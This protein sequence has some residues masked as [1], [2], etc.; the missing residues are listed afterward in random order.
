MAAAAKPVYRVAAGDTTGASARLAGSLPV[1]ARP[2]TNYAAADLGSQAGA[3]WLPPLGS[4]DG[5]WLWERDVAAA[6]LRDL[7]RNDGWASAGVDRMVDMLVGGIFRLNAKP[8]AD[9]LGITEDVANDLGRQIQAKWRGWA[10]DPTFRCDIER[11]LPF[12]GLMGLM[13]REFMNPGEA[14]SVL[15]W[16]R[17]P[18]WAYATAVQIIDSDRLSNPSGQPDTETL[19]G[20]VEKDASTHEP[21][22]Y[23]FRKGHPGDRFLGSASGFTW[24]RVPRWVKV[25]DWERPQVLHVY[26]KRR[27]GQSRGIAR[28]VA[29]MMKLRMLS[30]HSESEVGAAALNASIIGALYTQMG[31]DY[32][33]ERL[34][35]DKSGVDWGAFN[36]ERAAFYGDRK[37]LGDARLLTLFPTD[38]LE[39][40]SQPRQTAGYPAFQTSFL[41]SFAALLGIS[42][43]Q[44]SMDWSKTNYSSARAALNEVWRGV[45]RLRAILTWGA[46][47]PIYLAWLEEAIDIG[48]VVLPA[49]APDFYDAPAAY[50]RAQWIGSSRG[51]IDPVKEAQASVLRMRART[52]TLERESAEQGGDWEMDLAQLA[53][54]QA[55]FERLGL[56]APG[57]DLAVQGTSE[58]EG[59]RPAPADTEN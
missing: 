2:R 57:T 44:L 41:Q 49:G 43:E 7:D 27:P 9:A 53:R 56:A 50:C 48:E 20:G 4:A 11:Q 58:G 47:M 10:E 40:N 15:R 1:H 5:S 23:H 29:G 59:R 55:E 33:A 34:G 35:D 46:A 14:V 37:V 19:R 32:L 16:K 25:G 28:L 45:M 17:R 39:L 6:R 24:Q 52:S 26:D 51:Y 42:Y 54:E 21:I 22:A 13:A 12:A 30:R 38:K 36:E 3:G 18:G 31:S 8:D